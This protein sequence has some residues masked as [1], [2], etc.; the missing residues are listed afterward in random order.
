MF[1]NTQKMKIFDSF[2]FPYEK[3]IKEKNLFKNK[4]EKKFFIKNGNNIIFNTKLLIDNSYS[5]YF[6]SRDYTF[7]FLLPIEELNNNERKK[8]FKYLNI[9][10]IK[11]LVIHPYLQNLT[12]KK[13]TSFLSKYKKFL[14]GKNLI[15]STAIGSDKIYNIYP[16][17]LTNLVLKKKIFKNIIASHMGGYKIYE[18]IALMDTYDNLFCDTSFSLVYWHESNLIYD[19]NF[20]ISKFKKRVLYGSDNPF[21]NRIESRKKHNL[22]FKKFNYSKKIVESLLYKNAEQI[23]K[24]N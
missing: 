13:L 19:Q 11:N 1:V 14:I 4:I 12:E 8:F 9:Y 7:S 10:K 3:K 20:L 17:K 18:L 5:E 15:I 2:Y 22:F 23:F 6:K 24:K 21:I 16:L